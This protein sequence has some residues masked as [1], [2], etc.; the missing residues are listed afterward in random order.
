MN[1]WFLFAKCKFFGKKVEKGGVP[2]LCSLDDLSGYSIP[3]LPKLDS[4]KSG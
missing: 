4:S 2:I 1:E 3:G